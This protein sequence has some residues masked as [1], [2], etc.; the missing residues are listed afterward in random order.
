M[1]TTLPGKTRQDSTDGKAAAL[2][3]KDPGSNP[4]VGMKNMHHAEACLMRLWCIKSLRNGR[5]T[6]YQCT[7]IMITQMNEWQKKSSN[8]A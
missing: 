1:Y 6:E 2:F 7:R 5:M 3:S 8:K 4:V